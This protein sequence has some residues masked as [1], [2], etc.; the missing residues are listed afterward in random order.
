[1]YTFF[2]HSVY[3]VYLL[4]V[5][6][7]GGGGEQRLFFSYPPYSSISAKDR[8]ICAR[9]VAGNCRVF[10][11]KPKH[12]ENEILKLSG[13]TKELSAKLHG[14]GRLIPTVSGSLAP[15]WLNIKAPRGFEKRLL[16]VPSDLNHS[17]PVSCRSRMKMKHFYANK[18]SKF[19]FVITTNAIHLPCSMKILRVLIF[20]DFAD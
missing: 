17:N 14:A 12:R 13:K 20:A 19:S 9:L 2:I 15:N 1:M 7:G 8:N 4:S 6:G 18:V 5:T 3:A 16:E 10:L 11:S